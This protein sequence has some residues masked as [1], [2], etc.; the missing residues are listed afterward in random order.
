MGKQGKT[1]VAIRTLLTAVAA[2]SRSPRD[3]KFLEAIGLYNPKSNPALVDINEQR[4]LYWLGV[5]AQ[6]TETVRSILSQ[7]GILLKKELLKKKLSE[8]EIANK[9]SDWQKLKE[10][11]KS[12]VKK[13][14]K[15]S[16]KA[17]AKKAAEANEQPGKAAEEVNSTAS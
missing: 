15:L 3:G 1:A 7:Q 6:P 8:E 12:S 4:A 2:D 17:A 9:I 5:G 14:E 10:A 11:K 16:K 13:T